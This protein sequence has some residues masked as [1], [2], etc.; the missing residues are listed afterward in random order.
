MNTQARKYLLRLATGVLLFRMNP[1]CTYGKVATSVYG[2]GE[3]FAYYCSGTTETKSNTTKSG[4]KDAAV[5]QTH[6]MVREYIS[7]ARGGLGL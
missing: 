2:G 5:G 3:K 4:A 7:I 1:S 6:N